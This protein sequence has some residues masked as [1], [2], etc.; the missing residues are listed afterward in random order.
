MITHTFLTTIQ[1]ISAM[2]IQSSSSLPQWSLL[3]EQ[4]FLPDCWI[5]LL[6]LSPICL[7]AHQEV[8]MDLRSPSGLAPHPP[9]L[10]LALL[11]FIALP[12]HFFLCARWQY[13]KK[14]IRAG[15]KQMSMHFQAFKLCFGTPSL[16]ISFKVICSSFR[17]C[18]NRI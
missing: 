6:F 8:R 12:L 5:L 3:S 17:F 4:P 1:R 16:I 10:M 9:S 2:V 18:C 15:L 7:H 11:L 13:I 14:S